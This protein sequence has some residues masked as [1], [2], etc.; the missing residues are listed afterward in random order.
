M[1]I[2]H[3]PDEFEAV[4]ESRPC[5]ACNGDLRK[6]NGACNGMA[7]Y[8]LQRRPQAEIDKIKAERQREHDDNILAEAALIRLRRGNQGGRSVSSQ[9]RLSARAVA[10][11][12]DCS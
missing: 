5:S 9:S 1:Y 2:R 4:I 8:S 7:S 3:D 10:S 11:W 12:L 6:C